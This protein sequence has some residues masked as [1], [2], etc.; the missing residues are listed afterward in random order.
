MFWPLQILNSSLLLSALKSIPFRD[1]CFWPWCNSREN[2]KT[3][4][5]IWY[6]CFKTLCMRQN[7]TVNSGE[8]KKNNQS[9]TCYCT[10]LLHGES[11]QSLYKEGVPRQGPA[12]S[13]NCRNADQKPGRTRELEFVRQS[14]TALEFCR[15][16]PNLWALI[17]AFVREN[18]ITFQKEP[19]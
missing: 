15:E 5:N 19:L 17:D 2:K 3:E 1:F 14:K 10:S 6:N 13:P 9:E 11:F 18:Y 7:R 16:F 12:E 4:K 8:K